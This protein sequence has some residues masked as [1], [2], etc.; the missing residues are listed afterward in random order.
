ME[1]IEEEGPEVGLEGE[2]EAGEWVWVE[3]GGPAGSHR[4]GAVE[5]QCTH[6]AASVEG[7]LAYHV[8]A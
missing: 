5:D 1:F 3:E 8:E 4:V 6:E 7:V 2:Q